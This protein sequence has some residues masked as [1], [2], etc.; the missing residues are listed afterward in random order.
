MASFHNSIFAIAAVIIV[1]TSIL[2]QAQPN[3][4]GL[5]S[6]YA[7]VNGLKM[8]YEIHGTGQPLILVHG[9]L[10]SSDMFAQIVPELSK[11]RQVVAV[12]LQGHGHTAD[13]DRPMSYEAMADDI[14]AL[15]QYLGLE[16]PDVMGYSVGGAVALRTTVQHPEV[17][18]K[19]IIVSATFRRAGW[20]PEIVA[21][22]EHLDEAAAEQMKQTPMYQTYQQIAPRSQDWPVLCKKLGVMFKKDYD[23]SSEVAASRLP[24]CSSLAMPMQSAQRMRWNSSSCW[25]EARR[26]VAG[27]GQGCPMPG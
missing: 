6:G 27:T 11:S 9:G 22:M 17:V 5:R 12:D 18:R 19:L 15:I 8:Y 4:T 25:A 7:P 23:W 10:G 1:T 21:G 16:K 14:A 24:C 3:S 13:I 2:T 20:Y 26:M